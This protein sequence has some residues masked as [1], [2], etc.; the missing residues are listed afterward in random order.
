M[1]R[2]QRKDRDLV[3]TV[4]CLR[5]VLAQGLGKQNQDPTFLPLRIH[6]FLVLGPDLLVVHTARH[7]LLDRVLTAPLSLP[8]VLLCGRCIL[9]IQEHTTKVVALRRRMILREQQHQ[10]KDNRNP[11]ALVP[12]IGRTHRLS[13]LSWKR[14]LTQA[15]M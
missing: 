13:K 2:V 5:R 11:A 8:R 14:S 1:R 3:L 9:N 6:R 7:L 15:I 12:F 4:W 10:C